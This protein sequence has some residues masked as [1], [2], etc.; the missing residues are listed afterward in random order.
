M[1][2]TQLEEHVTKVRR[3]ANL[4]G[5]EGILGSN[6]LGKTN[7]AKIPD[8]VPLSNL[9]ITGPSSETEFRMQAAK[10]LGYGTLLN[11]PQEEQFYTPFEIPYE[12]VTRETCRANQNFRKSTNHGPHTRSPGDHFDHP[13]KTD[14]DEETDDRLSYND[15]NKQS[16]TW[17][18][19]RQLYQPSTVGEDD[20]LRMNPNYRA[21]KNDGLSNGFRSGGMYAGSQE[22]NSRAYSKGKYVPLG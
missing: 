17:Q 18:Y 16:V 10:D 9:S 4:S 20:H 21:L 8:V 12:T 15:T 13:M 14:I 1:S 11:T 5:F 19:G 3:L 22:L 7:D 2:E 6:K